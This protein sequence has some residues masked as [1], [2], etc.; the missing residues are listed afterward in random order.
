MIKTWNIWC[1]PIPDDSVLLIAPKGILIDRFDTLRGP[2][3][4]RGRRVNQILFTRE[5]TDRE[6]IIDG[7]NS[8]Y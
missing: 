8:L 3:L 6:K 2:E 1:G 4:G 5:L 7:E